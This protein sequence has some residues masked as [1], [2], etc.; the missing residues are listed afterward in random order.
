MNMKMIKGLPNHFK[1][2]VEN[3]EID[4][5]LNHIFPLNYTNNNDE[6][7]EIGEV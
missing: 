1:Q 2:N 6:D 5:I 4:W 3:T 7:G